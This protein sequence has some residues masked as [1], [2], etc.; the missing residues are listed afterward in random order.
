MPWRLRKCQG[1]CLIFQHQTVAQTF[2]AQ[3]GMLFGERQDTRHFARCRWHGTPGRHDEAI[4]QLVVRRAFAPPMVGRRGNAQV[5]QNRGE[6]FLWAPRANLGNRAKEGRLLCG[7]I[8]M[9]R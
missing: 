4:R 8:A 6:W 9:V 2:V 1:K 5:P 7:S 3:T